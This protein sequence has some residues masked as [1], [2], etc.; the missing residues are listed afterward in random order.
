MIMLM[1]VL[2]LMVLTN[3]FGKISQVSGYLNIFMAIPV[4]YIL[5]KALTSMDGANM[6]PRLT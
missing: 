3:S 1:S 5:Q 6:R 2:C 4:T